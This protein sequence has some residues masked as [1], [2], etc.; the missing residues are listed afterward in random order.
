MKFIV[1]PIWVIIPAHI[2]YAERYPKGEVN[3][4]LAA[5]PLGMYPG[6]ASPA[7]VSDHVL[8]LITAEPDAD[9]VQRAVSS[10]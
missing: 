2:G 7:G 1:T 8:L 3:L 10:P 9:A 6:G 4:P 5:L